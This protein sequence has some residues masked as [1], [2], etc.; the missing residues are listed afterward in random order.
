MTSAQWRKL[1][2]TVY[3]FLIKRKF[4]SFGRLSRIEFPSAMNFPSS[5]M[6]GDRVLVREHAYFNCAPSGKGPTLVIGNG[7]YIGRFSHFNAYE[8]VILEED[9][10]ISDRVFISDAHHNYS[11]PEKPIIRQGLTRAQPVRLKQG[12]WIGVGAVIMPGVTIGQNAIVAANAVVTR[13]LPDN[14]I[15]RGI[16]ARNYEK[17]SRER[18]LIT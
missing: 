10:L 5:M 4:C 1:I 16:P 15:A 3:S 14:M 12:C 6:I 2:A 11:D 7:S 13:D 18:S 8:S 17:K 9:V